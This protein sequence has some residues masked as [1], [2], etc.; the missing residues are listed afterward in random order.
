MSIFLRKG[1][2]KLNNVEVNINGN[3]IKLYGNN[4]TIQNEK[5][6]IENLELTGNEYADRLAIQQCIDDN[7]LKSDVLYEGNTVYPFEKTVKEYRRLQKSGTLDNMS[8]YMYHFFMYACDDIAHYDIGGYKCYYNNSFRKL[9]DE[10]LS[11]NWTSSRFADRD[12]IFKELKIS[13]E[14]FKE[15]ENI[16]IDKISLNELKSII[17][18]CGWKVNVDSNGFWKLS[19][20]IN[21][22]TNYSFNI[23]ILN[24]TTS[25]IMR[26]ISYITNSF[27][28]ENYI[29]NMVADR[30][31]I[32]NPP[33][34]SEIVSSAKEIRYSLI[35]FASDV[36]YKTRVAAEEKSSILN[37][38]NIKNN[39]NFDYEY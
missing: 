14:Y 32:D 31:K 8:K 28:Q 36:L 13:R 34:I 2:I 1:R 30:N 16:D 37:K 20:D 12:R 25:R 15:R 11:N 7:K 24:R 38:E 6:I 17:K 18:E 5:A 4:A 26:E 22:N 35:Q 29:E 10:L 23:D 9:E 3:R 39:D 27:N 19:K 33:T 21:Y